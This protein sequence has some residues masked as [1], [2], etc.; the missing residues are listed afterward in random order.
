VRDIKLSDLDGSV[1]PKT[2]VDA[3]ST[4]RDALDAVLRADDGRVLVLDADKPIGIVDANVIRQA[5][6]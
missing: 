4:L 5:S 6:R 2:T 1:A 3:G